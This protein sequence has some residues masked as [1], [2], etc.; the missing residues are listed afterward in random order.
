MDPDLKE[1]LVVLRI[2]TIAGYVATGTL[3]V[4]VLYRLHNRYFGEKAR[5]YRWVFIVV[6]T[7]TALLFIYMFSFFFDPQS[8]SARPALWNGET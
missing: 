5:K 2:F 6:A 7:I 1:L 8:S 4:A 3:M